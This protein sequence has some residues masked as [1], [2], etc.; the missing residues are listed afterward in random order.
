MYSLRPHKQFNFVHLWK[1]GFILSGTLIALAFVGFIA[2]T[3][4]TG[5]PLTL[6]TEFSGGTSIQIRN[7]GTITEEQV[8]DAYAAAA[9]EAGSNSVISSI[10]TSTDSSGSQ[11][12]IIK[13]T[14]TDSTISNEVMVNVEETLGLDAA[15]V[16]TETIGASWGSSVVW[17]S[18]LA[19]LL[20]C[21]GILILRRVYPDKPRGFRCPAV[22]IIAPLGFICCAFIFSEL[23]PHTLL[24]FGG[25]SV[26]GLLIYLV[27]GNRHSVLQKEEAG[28]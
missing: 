14:D 25:W 20:S 1:Y 24:L 19:F 4:V 7:A 18:I 11:G 23:S 8:S 10:Q 13:T 27:Y 26:L 3:I 9:A 16:Q 21:V 28:K 15:D 5:F 17:S 12:F 2:S 6:G 22:H